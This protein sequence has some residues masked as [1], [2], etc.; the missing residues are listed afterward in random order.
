MRPSC[1]RPYRRFKRLCMT[2]INHT[3]VASWNSAAGRCRYNIRP[4]SRSTWRSG[5]G[6]G[7]FDISHMGRL[8]FDGPGVLEWLERVTTNQVARLADDQIQYS[9]MT[10]DRGGVIDDILVYRQPFAFLVV[11]NASNRGNVVDATG[12]SSWRRLGVFSRS[13]RR[14]RDD[15]RPGPQGAGDTFSRCSTSRS[16]RSGIITSRWVACWG[17]LIRWSAGQDIPARTVSS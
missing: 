10:N 1:H 14:H 5:N 17:G 4:S 12:A 8:T 16:N 15:R 2:G 11:C 3:V 13:H 9:L 7:L 6:S